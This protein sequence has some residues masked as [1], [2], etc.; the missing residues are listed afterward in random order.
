MLKKLWNTPFTLGQL[1]GLP[2]LWSALYLLVW[3]MGLYGIGS[4]VANQYNIRNI[5]ETDAWIWWILWFWLS[6][7]ILVLAGFFWCALVW[8]NAVSAKY[9]FTTFVVRGISLIKI[10]ILLFAS[11]GLWTVASERYDRVAHIVAGTLGCMEY[12][13]AKGSVSEYQASCDCQQKVIR[14]LALPSSGEAEDTSR[15]QALDIFSR[16]WEEGCA[17]GPLDLGD[18]DEAAAEEASQDTNE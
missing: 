5:P 2:S 7:S 8:K 6:T 4:F 12:Q 16:A 10:I 1:F 13:S 17:T 15:A 11:Y 14:A 3:G 18:T 9:R